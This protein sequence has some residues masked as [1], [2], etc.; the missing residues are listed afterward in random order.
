M[1][2]E[3]RRVVSNNDYHFFSTS[4]ILK[5][6]EEGLS[7]SVRDGF[8]LTLAPLKVSISSDCLL[9]QESCWF[10]KIFLVV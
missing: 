10:I 3:K 2:V 1:V 4:C 7:L 5:L 9:A 6:L 8:K